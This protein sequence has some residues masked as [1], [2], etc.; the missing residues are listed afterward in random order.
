M[1]ETP[2]SLDGFPAVH[3]AIVN[4]TSPE[5]WAIVLGL[6]WSR[7]QEGQRALMPLNVPA[8]TPDAE[9]DRAMHWSRQAADVHFTLI[10]I[11]NVLRI[12]EDRLKATDNRR[13]KRLA[14]DFRNSFPDAWNL[15]DI[16]EHLLDYEAGQGKLQRAE[17]MPLEEGSPSLAYESLSDPEGE[18]LL[19]VGFDKRYIR[20][21][22]AMGKAFEI[23]Q[24][25]QDEARE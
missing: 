3:V 2:E 24:E 12:M 18:I 23:A 4:Q 17:Q 8:S 14:A 20:I 11:R 16:L 7:L 19:V 9:G 10:A 5:H 25:L 21:K 13:L 1:T 6:C 15:R 22:A